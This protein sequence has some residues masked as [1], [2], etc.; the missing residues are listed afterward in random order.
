MPDMVAM[1]DIHPYHSLVKPMTERGAMRVF[2]LL[3]IAF[4]AACSACSTVEKIPDIALPDSTAYQLQMEPRGI[5]GE[6][7][8]PALAAKGY[9]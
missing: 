2:S 6:P 9:C 8:P 4:A 7:C 3:V 5:V 1:Q